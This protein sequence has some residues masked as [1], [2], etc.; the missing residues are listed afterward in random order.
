MTIE[1]GENLA[2]LLVMVAFFITLAFIVWAG[3]R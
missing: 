3:S 2:G 1:I